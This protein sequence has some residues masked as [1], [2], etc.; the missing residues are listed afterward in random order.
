MRI[1]GR[2]ARIAGW[3]WTSAKRPWESERQ[4]CG[5][6]SL[7]SAKR[8][9]N[10]NRRH[11]NGLFRGANA[12][13][14]GSD[15]L[16]RVLDSSTAGFPGT[17]G[18]SPAH[19]RGFEVD[20][21]PGAARDGVGSPSLT[22]PLRRRLLPHWTG[23]RRMFAAR[24]PRAVRERLALKVGPLAQCA[25][26]SRTRKTP[27]AQGRAPRAREKRLGHEKNRSRTRT[28]PRA[29]QKPLAWSRSRSGRAGAFRRRFEGFFSS[30]G[31]PVCRSGLAADEQA[32]QGGGS[33]PP[34]GS[35]TSD[36]SSNRGRL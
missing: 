13:R 21:D 33:P 12:F 5:K 15:G 20:G 7:R 19:A 9:A 26:A 30:T 16:W 11:A 4:K 34:A 3:P 31:M 6:T 36:A 25:S 2:P 24:A 23:V 27:R 10:G 14:R 28:A 22:S 35:L 8:A 1:A 29:R 32:H 18:V 17:A